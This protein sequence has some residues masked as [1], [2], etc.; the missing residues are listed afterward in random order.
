MDQD[1][2][3]SCKD[4]YGLISL[5]KNGDGE[6]AKKAFLQ[7]LKSGQI[8]AMASHYEGNLP[9]LSDFDIDA[10]YSVSENCFIQNTTDQILSK[11]FWGLD[12]PRVISST[13]D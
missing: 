13:L 1:S 10:T 12:L 8:T 3:L 2:W 5:A 6:E 7:L 9:E 11:D 4:A